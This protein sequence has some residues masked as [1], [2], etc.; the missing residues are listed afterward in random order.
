MT[1]QYY[2]EKEAEDILFKMDKEPKEF[3]PLINDICRIDCLCYVE[4]RIMKFARTKG[5]KYG[6]HNGYCSNEMF[7]YSG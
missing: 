6:V 4:A 5:V 7:T 1:T 2:T 3:C